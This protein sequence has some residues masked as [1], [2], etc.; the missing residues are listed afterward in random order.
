MNTILSMVKAT[1]IAIITA[2]ITMLSACN[3][4]DVTDNIEISLSSESSYKVNQAILVTFSLSNKASYDIQFLKWG[5]PFESMPTRD[6][7]TV[8]KADKQILPYQGPMVK[9]GKPKASD[10]ITIRAGETLKKSVDISKPYGIRAS[11]IYSVQY[12]QSYPSLGGK[13]ALS[14]GKLT[15]PATNSVS[16]Q[17]I[18]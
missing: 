12:K 1:L 6:M 13:L 14:N 10:Y 8:K 18:K 2:T 17:V 11:G 3:S 15:L 5:T 16:F 9:R 4:E 7:F